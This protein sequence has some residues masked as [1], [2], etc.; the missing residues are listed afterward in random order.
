MLVM[1]TPLIAQEKSPVKYGKIAPE[2]FKAGGPMFDSSAKAVVIADIGSSDF[3]GNK[4]SS[5]SI[6]FDRFTRIIILD[7]TGIDAATVEIPLYTS[8]NDAERV[9]GLKAHTYNME[10]GKIT[11]TKM[12]TSAVF[13]EKRSKNISIMKFTLPAVKPGSIIEYNY[14]LISDFLFNLQDWE[15]QGQYPRLWSEYYTAIPEYFRYVTISQIKRP[16]DVDKEGTGGGRWSLLLGT[17]SVEQAEAVTLDGTINTHRWVMK[18]VPAFKEEP[19]TSS[20]DNHISKLE[21][22]LAMVQWPQSPPKM[23]MNSWEKVSEELMESFDFGAQINKPNNWLDDDIRSITKGAKTASEKTRLI[24]EYVR[25]HMNSTGSKGIYA[26]EDLSK[27]WKNKQGSVAEVNLVLACMLAHEK[28]KV[29]PVILST[30]EHGFTNETYPILPKYNYVICYVEADGHEYLLDANRKHMGFGGLHWSLYNGQGR[31][32]DPKES[33]PISLLAD[34]LQEKSSTVMNLT[35]TKD[36]TWT[37]DVTSVLGTYGSLDIRD[38]MASKEGKEAWVKKKQTEIGNDAQVSHVE[39]DSLN[40]LMDPVT[41]NYIFTYKGNGEED[42]IYLNPLLGEA[43][44][45]NPFKSEK[46]EYPVEMPY[47]INE[48]IIVYA[49]IPE[50]YV[51]EELPQSAKVTFNGDEGYLECMYYKSNTGFQLKFVFRLNT[52]NFAADSYEDLR[53]FFGFMLKKQSEPVVLKK[54]K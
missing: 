3:A 33:S 36:G 4:K 14:T 41:L 40:S 8:G 21:F 7:K 23:V 10:G 51:V 44:K 24:F 53:G 13:V 19:F 46:R 54:K 18:N 12:E 20:P 5:F 35:G 27:V 48:T 6:Q 15:F 28:I 45:N 25:D 9:E 26:R 34:S 16:F 42:V 1:T 39:V 22:Q 38:E 29:A 31:L 50:G 49:T 2:D 47:T 37:A 30:K 43:T 52:A 11:E 17:N 32:I